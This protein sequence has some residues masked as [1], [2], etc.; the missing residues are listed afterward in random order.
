MQYRQQNV[1]PATRGNF[2][3]IV[4]GLCSYHSDKIHTYQDYY[5]FQLME[6]LFLFVV[7]SL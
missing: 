3:F 7:L 1:L 5:H 2:L 4:S 6:L